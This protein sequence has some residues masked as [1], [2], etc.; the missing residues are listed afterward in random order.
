[1]G[2][3]EAKFGRVEFHRLLLVTR[4]LLSSPNGLK[5]V[6]LLETDVLV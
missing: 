2:G 4:S 5:R 6:E 3:R 1:M